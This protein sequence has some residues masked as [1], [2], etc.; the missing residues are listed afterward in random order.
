MHNYDY[1]NYCN[2][3][4]FLF[5]HESVPGNNWNTSDT[6]RF[7]RHSGEGWNRSV[8]MVFHQG[9]REGERKGERN[10]DV[11][12]HRIVEETQIENYIS[13]NSRKG[14]CWII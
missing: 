11:L 14:L 7:H 4:L 10:N 12:Y 1:I 3:N 2:V 5:V 9:E 8:T 6:V 13:L